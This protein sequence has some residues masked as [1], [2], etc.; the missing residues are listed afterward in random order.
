ML[1]HAEYLPL[2]TRNV[3]R[4]TGIAYQGCFEEKVMPRVRADSDEAYVLGLCD[5]VLG[6]R[7]SRQHKFDCLRGDSRDDRPG[8]RLPVDAYYPN[9]VLAIEYRE[10][11]HVEQLAFFDKPD[12]LTV[13]GVHRGKQRLLY[14]QRRREVLPR[15]GIELIEISYSDFARGKNGQLLRKRS[16][17]IEVLRRVLA[18]RIREV[19]RRE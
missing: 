12:R 5:E 10:R 8:R 11:Q 7:A 19:T 13:S 4:L 15:Q 17:D 2:L 16:E 1:Q 14:D 3:R 18:H 9:L 6:M